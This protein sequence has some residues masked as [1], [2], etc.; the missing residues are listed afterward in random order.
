MNPSIDKL[1]RLHYRALCIYALH[2]LNDH[3]AVEDVVQESFEMLWRRL[4]AGLKVENPKSYLYTC[5]K[6]RCLGYLGKSN[7]VE[8]VGR[9][10]DTLCEEFE[11]DSEVEAK[12]WGAIGSLPPKCREIFLMG[13]RDGVKYEEI[14]EELGISLQTVKNQMSK[15][16]T[17][18]KNKLTF[19]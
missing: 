11:R 12:I 3:D 18:L 4:N 10:S 16:L 13:K 2:F 1:F 7:R 5:V 6:N 8:E 17:V 9:L 14:A 19:K 15:A